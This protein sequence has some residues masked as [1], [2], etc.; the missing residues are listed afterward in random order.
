VNPHVRRYD[1]G[2]EWLLATSRISGRVTSPERTCRANKW[3][4]GDKCRGVT[5]MV[6]ALQNHWNRKSEEN[7]VSP[8][9][10][11]VKVIARIFASPIGNSR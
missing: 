1:E 7:V 6:F 2:G 10:N 3:G 11:P 9:Q 8:P 5:P 4:S